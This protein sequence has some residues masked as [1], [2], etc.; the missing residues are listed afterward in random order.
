MTPVDTYLA[1]LGAA[2]HGSGREKRDLLSEVRD[3]LTDATQAR[4]EA[5]S[6]HV[7]AEADAIGEFGAVSEIAPSYQ[8]V[9]SAGQCRR[10]S[11]WLMVLVIAQPLAWDLWGALPISMNVSGPQ[12]AAFRVADTYVEVVGATALV[13]AAM[14]LA[15]GRIAFRY[16]GIREWMLRLVLTCTLVSSGLIMLISAAMATTSAQ[17]GMLSTA[18]AAVVSW[19]PMALLGTACVRAMRAVDSTT[20]TPH[21]HAASA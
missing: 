1:A 17:T 21:V 14:A 18:Y 13:L 3:H 4:V 12:S 15:G 20:D 5:G 9:L 8:A 10:L 6:P 19:L 7:D 11:G 2:L 16:L